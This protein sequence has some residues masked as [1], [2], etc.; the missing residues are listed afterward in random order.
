M[1]SQYTEIISSVLKKN[2][3][4]ETVTVNEVVE[5]YFNIH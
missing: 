1:I 2:I 4:L 5:I 3:T